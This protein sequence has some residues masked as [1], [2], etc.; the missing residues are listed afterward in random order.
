[1]QL[2]NFLKLLE[3]KKDSVLRFKL[4]N[5]NFVEEHFHVTEVGKITKEFIDCGGTN[6]S[7]QTCLLQLWIAND[8]EHRVNAG[9]LHSIFSL[10]KHIYM[11]DKTPI[12]VQYGSEQAVIYDVDSCVLNE[13]FIDITLRGQKTDC[14]APD[15]CGIKKKCCGDKCKNTKCC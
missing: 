15:K 3:E 14:L 7:K 12:E 13:N 2:G 4:P 5:G 6:R 1:M 8:E 10:A 11:D 9:K